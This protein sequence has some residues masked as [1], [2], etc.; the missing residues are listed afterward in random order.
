MAA[1][2]AEVASGDRCPR[3]VLRD[4]SHRSGSVA[5]R[6]ATALS[7]RARPP[8]WVVEA[9]N[10]ALVLLADHE[11]AT[12]TLAARVAAST[13]AD[14]YACVVA[15]L[16]TLSGPLHGTASAAVRAALESDDPAERLADQASSGRLSGF[17]HPLYE[18]IDPRA[19]ALLE[20]V[21]EGAPNHPVLRAADRLARVVERRS[22]VAANV[23]LGL[24]ALTAAAGLSAEAGSVIF[25]V[26]RAAGWLAHVAEEYA[27]PPLRFRS[28]AVAVS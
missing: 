27:E 5:A 20:R 4:G 15:A 14:P 2:V 24:A 6:L 12:S 19:S 13:R 9:T 28:R 18:G 10:A 1:M 11:L 7:G 23:D 3:L 22:G 8:G 21:R 26:A 25:A 16:A 17:G